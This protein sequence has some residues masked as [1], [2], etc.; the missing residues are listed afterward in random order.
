MTHTVAPSFAPLSQTDLGPLITLT[1]DGAGTV[2]GSHQENICGERGLQVGVNITSITGT[3]TVN[4]YGVDQASA[5]SYLLLA[6]AAYSSTGFHELNLFPGA[7]AVANVTAN[8]ELPAKWFVQTVV[9]TGPCTATVGAA[10][11]P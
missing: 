10:T 5:Q 7:T 1:A 2:N 11:I 6:S 3:L 8:M 4:I 9:V